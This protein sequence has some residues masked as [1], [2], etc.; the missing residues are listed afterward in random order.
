MIELT[1]TKV[2]KEQHKKVDES[3]PKMLEQCKKE[4]LSKTVESCVLRAKTLQEL[5]SCHR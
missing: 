2:P 4:N 1:K 3:K 5:D